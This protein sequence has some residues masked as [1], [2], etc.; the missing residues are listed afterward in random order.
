MMADGDP[1]Q[2]VEAV[3]VAVVGGGIA[4]LAAAHDLAGAGV[5]VVVLEAG[6]R[7]GG[8]IRVRDLAGAPVDVGADSLVARHRVGVDL[9]RSLD[10]ELVHPATGDVQLVV[11]G[12]LRGLPAGAP[13]G[14]P[15]D[16]VAL[17]R[18]GV[19]SPVGLARAALEGVWPRR[20]HDPA[21]RSVAEVVAARYGDEVV[22]RLVEPM[23]GGIY[24][25]R[26][27]RLSV[28]A[29]T[30]L[31]ADADRRG[32]SLAHALQ[33]AIAARPDTPV[34]ATPR[35]LMASLPAALADALGAGVVRTRHAVRSIA[36][37][38]PAWTIE[39]D[40]GRDADA[41]AGAGGG[42]GHGTE[43]AP[44]ASLH[45]AAVVLA[46]PA[47]ATARLLADVAP[48]S[49][50]ELA[51]VDHASVAVVAL[52][53]GADVDAL[54]EA[55]GILVPRREG[56]LVKGATWLGR[57]WPHLAER[58]AVLRASVGRID[59]RR[60]QSL[61]DDELVAAVDAEVRHLTGLRAARR[62]AVVQRWP[63]ALPQYDVGH[64]ALV[65]RV[66][67]NLPAGLLLAGGAY[68][69]IGV[70]P[71]IASG[72]AAAS[73]AAEHATLG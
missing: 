22:D 47:H 61:D 5:D 26:P 11:G 27:D 18:S 32:R 7:V 34:F 49:A 48:G 16:L 17:A 13:F 21:D 63:R 55:S 60:F 71:C 45:A 4:G 41:G 36:A 35:D 53:Y 37:D 51:L 30:P 59:D 64:L 14:V 46:T 33:H 10:L 57:K 39:V 23:L 9:A 6:S 66:R 15:T 40:R 42:G 2:A 50:A 56:R 31:V 58:G 20:P 25:G 54:P 62:D 69:G 28:E 12:R 72:R 3:D 73:G 44:V 1:D 67:R 52:H 29:T 38:G 8:K 70:S 24:A 43:R 65:D 68:D 19:L